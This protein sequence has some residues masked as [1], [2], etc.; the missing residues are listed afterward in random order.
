MSPRWWLAAPLLL[1]ACGRYNGNAADKL[2]R[3]SEAL[4]RYGDIE[5]AIDVADHGWRQWKNEPAAEWHWKFR[6]LEAELLLNQG[7]AARALALLQEGGG[8]PSSGE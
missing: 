2:Y 7:S 1:I 8:A 5:K 6:L 3:Q 4:W